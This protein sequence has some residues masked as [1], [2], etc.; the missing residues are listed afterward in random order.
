MEAYF[1]PKHPGSFRGVES[2]TRHT[3][4]DVG[5]AKEWLSAK[6]AYTLHKQVKSKFRRRKTYA[7][8]INELW[9]ADLVDLS[10]LANS[11]SNRYLLTCIDVFSK[12][13]RVEPLKA[14]TGIALM[15]AF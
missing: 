9:Q 6:D 14:K 7:K 15:R 11:D 4:I 2:I 3:G 10:S 5:K 12:V 1:D 8:G 13:A